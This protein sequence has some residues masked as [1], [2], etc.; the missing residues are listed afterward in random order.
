MEQRWKVLLITSVGLFMASLDLFIVNIAFPD[1]A[2]D[3]D[4]ASISN[5]SWVLN[6]YAIVFAALLVPAGR[7]ADR[8]GRKRVFIAGL[9]L[10][11][12]ASALCA[13]SP[14]IPFL[15]AARVLQ[16]AGGAMMLPTT[17]GL[18]LPAFP[19]QQRALAI[20]IW[21]AVGG[22]AAALGP[23][24]GGLLVQVS[25]H[26]I[27]LVNVPI[28][29]VTAIVAL[30]ALDEV[31]EPEDGRP[32]LLGAAALAL[33]IG[34]LTLGIVK[35]PD[36]G[37]TDPRA[38][39]SFAGAAAL[40]VAFVYRSAHHHAPVIELPLLRVRSFALGN[41]A[42]AVFFAGFAA[43]LL[44]GVLLL[45]EVWGYSA[46]R[47]GIALSPG[48]LMAALF[49]IPSGR[50][51]GRIGQPPRR[52]R[53]R[54]HLRCRLRLHPRQ[55]RSQPRIRDHLPARLHARR[56]RGRD[57]AGNPAGSRHR[58]PTAEPVRDR[59]RGLRD[60][61]PARLGDRRRRSGGAP[62]RGRER[63]RR[64][65]GRTPARLVV[66][67][68]R[69]SRHRRGRLRLRPSWRAG[70]QSCSNGPRSRNRSSLATSASR[71]A[72]VISR[73]P[74]RRRISFWASSIWRTSSIS[75]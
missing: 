68:D 32:D 57:G 26:W 20:G 34:L 5:L 7:I 74:R 11:S 67:P 24:L 56:R 44:S 72:A 42:A 55:R 37:W 9:L 43:M 1:L 69:R 35:G 64:P 21:S 60:V 50:L 38:L 29:I 2:A 54:P 3:F 4:G 58:G 25:W 61:A 65:P 73:A 62:G 33:G 70:Y 23:P 49:S 30:R 36:W 14:S 66:L 8:V 40:I 17:L 46:L 27:F 22:V 63:R 71:S 31:R 59:Y 75:F 51:G 39:A 45:T 53:G 18:I 47:A 10:F 12:L 48:P 15:V 13:V 6:A 41:L 19:A 16:A 28:G 52:R